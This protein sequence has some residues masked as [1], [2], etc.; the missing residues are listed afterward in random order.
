MRTLLLLFAGLAIN[1]PAL[2][3]Q[4]GYTHAREMGLKGSIKTVKE[5]QYEAYKA[6]DSDIHKRGTHYH[7]LTV[8]NFNPQG[9]IITETAY[10]YN[11]NYTKQPAN[12]TIA[13][14]TKTVYNYNGSVCTGYTQ[15][16][17]DVKTKLCERTMYGDYS[18][19]D[20]IYAYIQPGGKQSPITCVQ[21]Y[22][23]SPL[24]KLDSTH[25]FKYYD[26]TV[27]IAKESKR[28]VVYL[29][30]AG[31]DAQY[32][33][34]LLDGVH[35]RSDAYDNRLE[36]VFEYFEDGSRIYEISEY[37]YEYY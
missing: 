11:T 28:V 26:I 25:I 9:N 3:Q 33:M 6:A 12:D 20:S 17:N 37:V 32:T 35:L 19:R 30:K 18:Y 7:T 23:Y 24:Y 4:G 31:N 10:A 21:Q 13:S 1:S 2:C 14:V 29:T 36:D 15:Y 27:S 16:T 34:Q 8:T 5:Y 22:Y